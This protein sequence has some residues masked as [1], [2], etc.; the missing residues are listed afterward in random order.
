MDVIDSLSYDDVLLLPGYSDFLPSETEVRSRL[1]GDIHLNIPIISA[2][3]DTVTEEELAIAIALAGGAG[4]IHRN[5]SPELQATQVSHVKRFLNWIIE[6]PLT[7]EKEQN[8]QEVWDIMTA[9]NVSGLPVLDGGKLCGIITSRDMRFCKDYSLK[10]EDIMTAS[11]ITVTGVPDME[12]AKE[13]FNTHKIEKLPVV[14]D[15]GILTGLITVKD[16]EKHRNFPNAAL[17]S[18]G[19]LVVGAAVSPM[20]YESRIP[21][22]LKNKVDFIAIDTAHGDSANVISACTEIKKKYSIP[23]I[24]GNVATKAAAQR[25]VNAGAD[26]IKV[27]IG[28]GSICT[29]RIV[30]GIGVPQFSAVLWCT[31]I[32]EKHDI[33]VIADGGIKFS[34]DITKAVAAGAS[35]VMI[36]NLFAGLRE[37]PG[38]EI[39]YEGRIFKSYRGMGSI[40]ALKEG[41]GDRYQVTGNEAL[42]PEG[43]EGRV[44]YKG[45]LMPYIHQ[46]VT[47]LKKGMGY[48]GCR[49][50][51]ELRNYRKFVK[52]SSAGLKESHAHDVLITQ[53]P[54]NYS[55]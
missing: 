24:A 51:E 15:T 33:P 46:L 30:A 35:T 47:G 44:P 14:D 52:I 28:P 10:I 37:S 17:D 19:R 49:N 25:L 23:V 31:E 27:G 5:M 13:K 2:A 1:V 29:T 22:L 54:P 55:R 21:L 36:G 12:S 53:E 26:A 34:G 8:L 32:A 50:L 40:G 18:H 45:E 16:L 39:I 11:P 3:M 42:V 4:V 38:K 41:S 6:S 43:I 9:N 48:C 20:D 7:V